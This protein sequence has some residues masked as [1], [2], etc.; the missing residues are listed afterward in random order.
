E[1]SDAQNTEKTCKA[2]GKKPDA[3]LSFDTQNEAN[4]AVSSGRADLGFA[5]SQ[6][7]AYIVHQSHG[8][9][10]L[11]GAAIEVAPYGFA[12]PKGSTLDKATLAAVK[13]LM[14][15]GIYTK[16]LDLWGVQPGAISN[17]MINPMVS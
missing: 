9:F 7:A 1:Q 13:I 6:V 16:I 17:P 5:D 11:D 10:K 8:Q 2:A 15:D 3:V 4:L 14:K 12:F